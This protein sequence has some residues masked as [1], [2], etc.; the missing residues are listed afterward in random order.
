MAIRMHDRKAARMIGEPYFRLMLPP[1]PK[2]DAASEPVGVL[3]ITE[4]PKR[5][6]VQDIE[7]VT[8]RRRET[9]V[10]ADIYDPREPEEMHL[11]RLGHGSI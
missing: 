2:T 9:V 8:E 4:A 6:K 7:Y 11:A 5:V 3:I 1:K 10:F